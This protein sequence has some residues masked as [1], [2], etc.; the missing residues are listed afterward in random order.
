MD[1]RLRCEQSTE[2]V[3]LRTGDGLEPSRGVRKG[4]TDGVGRLIL[5]HSRRDSSRNDARL[6]AE[7]FDGRDLGLVAPIESVDELVDEERG[8][9]TK[10]LLDRLVLNLRVLNSD[11]TL[12]DTDALRVLVEDRIDVLSGPERVLVTTLGNVVYITRFAS[13]LLEPDLEA[14]VEHGNERSGLLT[15]ALGDGEEVG[16]VLSCQELLGRC[17]VR[18]EELL[19]ELGGLVKRRE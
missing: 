2:P 5:G 1:D 19:D 9:V 8:D 16:L 11:G 18:L 6:G 4:C 15:G 17:G 12:E 3:E 14:G 7:V 10:E 13:Y